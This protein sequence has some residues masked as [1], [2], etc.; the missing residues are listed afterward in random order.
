LKSSIGWLVAVGE[1][2]G[3]AASGA[4]PLPISATT[5]WWEAFPADRGSAVCTVWV[6][7][8]DGW[9]ADGGLVGVGVGV[10]G[11][12]PTGGGLVTDAPMV[13]VDIVRLSEV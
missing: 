11:F 2:A 10:T 1:P 13:V 5:G 4:V 9:G 12:G 6:G 8:T 7:A 3:F